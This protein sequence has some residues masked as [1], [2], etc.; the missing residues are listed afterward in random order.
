MIKEL[1]TR[2][3]KNRQTK[4]PQY[5]LRSFARDLKISP[6]MI[7]RFISGE[8]VPSPE[9]LGQ[10]LEIID[11]D[12]SLKKQIF[13]SLLSKN[14][15][16][17]PQDRDYQELDAHQIEK[18]NHWL[19]FA[20][21]ELFRS[22]NRKFTSRTISKSLGQPINE[23]EEKIL[24]LTQMG[25]VKKTESGFKTINAKQ[26]AKTSRSV[27]DQ[28]HAGY[29]E[30]AKESMTSSNET[31]RSV[32]GTT[33]L[34]NPKRLPEAFERIKL[35]RRSLSSFLEVKPGEKEEVLYRI[36]LA[37]FSLEKD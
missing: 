10:I 28:I 9:T 26:T 37:L 30:Q 20:L 15:F 8:R 4:N 27:L 18:L 22:S 17:I 6:S 31:K 21:L 33:V 7:S 1:L 34:L 11:V 16:K 2:E 32:S 35:F 24:I 19:F 12:S 14:D 25:L 5:S 13:D 29:L 3:L 36:Q 23:I